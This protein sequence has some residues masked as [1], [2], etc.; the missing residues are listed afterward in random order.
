MINND[1]KLKK[2]NIKN[3]IAVVKKYKKITLVFW[4]IGASS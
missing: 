4:L 2:K 3:L 1:S